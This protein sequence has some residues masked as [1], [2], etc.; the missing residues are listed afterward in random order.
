MDNRTIFSKT[1]RGSL[2]ITKKGI[3]LAADERQALILVDGKSNL[4][5]LQEKLGKIAPPRMQAIFERLLELDLIRIFVT[6]GGPD[7][8][9]SIAGIGVQEITEDDLDFTAFAP[10]T[11]ARPANEG[12]KASEAQRRAAEEAKKQAAAEQK[13]R[14]AAELKAREI[15]ARA[16][17]E[18]AEHKAREEAERKARAHAEA[19]ERGR[20]EEEAKRRAIAQHQ[21]REEARQIG[22]GGETQQ[23]EGQRRAAR[24]AEEERRADEEASRY[25]AALTPHLEAASAAPVLTP[26]GAFSNLYTLDPAGSAALQ[27][28]APPATPAPAASAMDAGEQRSRKELER[29]A[30]DRAKEEARARKQAEK[31]AKRLAN[32]GNAD[33]GSLLRVGKLV[34]AVMVLVL[35]SAAAYVFSLSADK[36][37]IEKLLTARFGVPVTV[38]DATFSAFPAELRMSNVMLGDIKL[39]RVVAS[40][41][42]S[43]LALGEKV[44][45][46]V[47]VTGLE[48]DVAQVERLA[49]WAAIEPA[50]RTRAF[51]LQ[52]IRAAAVAI[53]G[54]PINVPKF[55]AT[56]L[57]ASN[58]T[59]KQASL[60]LPDGKAQV[61]LSP[62]EK[63]WL[64]DIEARGVAWPVGPKVAWESLRSKGV[65]NRA[66]M[67]LDEFIVTHAGGN[68]RGTGMLGWADGW[69][70]TGS[71]EVNGIDADGISG[72]LYRASPVAGPVEGKFSVSMAAPTLA[73]L[74]EAPQVEGNFAVSRAVLKTLDFARLLQ[75]ASAG[76]QTRLPEVTGSLAAGNGRLQLRQLRGTSG[77]LSI[78][79][80]VDITPEAA[81]TGSLIV[82]LGTAG[83][84]GRTALR[85]G[86]SVAEPRF[87]K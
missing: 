86:G 45:R 30:A 60:T 50:T 10:V 75:G 82:E 28:A 29:E 43:N 39:P 42:L 21:A 56:L 62:E 49:A 54:T 38:G 53:N 68:A 18:A 83:S 51:A 23:P 9:I 63:G 4:G 72:M 74:F 1:G 84:R 64:V 55:N 27:A 14:E 37:A 15:V 13:A 46:N 77:T 32:R 67:K 5:E 85:V 65:A 66:G 7:S 19:R 69:R 26:M 12:T 20:L 87:E 80:N 11:P 41:S 22:A 8:I 2:E 6:K 58:G 17:R 24:Q 35:G 73:R 59:V 33:A 48:L 3:K 79:G 16:A 57:L 70:F 25:T 78:A 76:G 47:D 44:W 40:S 34:A 36:P 71:V 31:E 61:L 52:R 81:L